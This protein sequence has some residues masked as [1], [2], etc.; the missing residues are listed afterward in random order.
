ML[1]IQKDNEKNYTISA[2]E[3]V[4]DD[5]YFYNCI[6]TAENNVL[7]ALKWEIVIMNDSLKKVKSVKPKQ[8]DPCIKNSGLFGFDETFDGIEFLLTCDNAKPTCSQFKSDYTAG[9]ESF[10]SW[11]TKVTWK[12]KDHEFELL[13]PE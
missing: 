12:S 2:S 5:D 3:T 8:L 13:N 7:V 11:V 4:G 10:D 6:I 1:K 9:T